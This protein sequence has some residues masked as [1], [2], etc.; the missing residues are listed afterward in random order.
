MK[1]FIVSVLG[2]TL[3]YL[4]GYCLLAAGDFYGKAFKLQ[5]AGICEPVVD[6]KGLGL[7]CKAGY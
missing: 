3:L 6:G 5:Q 2:L 4:V 1:E 7:K